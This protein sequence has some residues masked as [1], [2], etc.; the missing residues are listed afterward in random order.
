LTYPNLE[1]SRTTN[2]GIAGE[3]CLRGHK[4]PAIEKNYALNL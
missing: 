3:N 1:K 2:S 4:K